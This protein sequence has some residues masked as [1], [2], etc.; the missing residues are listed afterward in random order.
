TPDGGLIVHGRSDAT[1]NVNGVRIGTAEIY[2]QVEAVE[3]VLESVVVTEDLQGD[4][5]S[6]LFVRLKQGVRLDADLSNKIRQR[7]REFA[8]PRHV[9]NLIVEV[10]DI[11]KTMNGKI[12]ELAVKDVIHG[13]PARN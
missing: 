8:S 10:A 2:R 5:R 9:P 6:I 4:S 7:I 3:D 12:S 11:P 1:L 13:R